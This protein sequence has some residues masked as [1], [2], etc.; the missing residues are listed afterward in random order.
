MG[1]LGITKALQKFRK[2]HLNLYFTGLM[3]RHGVA[4]DVKKPQSEN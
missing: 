2:T 1:W 3:V 4:W